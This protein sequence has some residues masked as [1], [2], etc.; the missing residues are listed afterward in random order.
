MRKKVE[1]EE[2][3]CDMCGLKLFLKPGDNVPTGWS[4][5]FVVSTENRYGSL[6]RK[7]SAVNSYGSLDRK[8]VDLCQI[9]TS[10]AEK[11]TSLLGF[12]FRKN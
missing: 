8:T 3:I 4:K 11:V 9:C 10:N 12:N 6:S 5:M 2:V 7:T 1:C